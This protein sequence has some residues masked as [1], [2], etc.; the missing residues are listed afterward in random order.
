MIL[1]ATSKKGKKNYP[2]SLYFFNDLLSN[3]SY[4]E[5]VPRKVSDDMLNVSQTDHGVA[6][7]VRIVAI[8]ANWLSLFCTISLFLCWNFRTFKGG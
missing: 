7:M 3:P 2:G 8:S 5:I 1:E 6:D 4:K